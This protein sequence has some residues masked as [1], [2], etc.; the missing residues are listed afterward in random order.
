[1]PRPVSP[2]WCCSAPAGACRFGG[3]LRRRCSINIGRQLVTDAGVEHR[4]SL[5]ALVFACLATLWISPRLTGRTDFYCKRS[6]GVPLDAGTSARS[7]KN[8]NMLAGWF[9]TSRLQ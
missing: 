5:P 2:N 4:R 9:P 8:V 1:M 6:P 7:N 3:E